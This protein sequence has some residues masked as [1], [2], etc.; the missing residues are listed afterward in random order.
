MNQ[1]IR[2]AWEVE[3]EAQAVR[4][5]AGHSTTEE[6]ERDR[7]R[8]AA[9]VAKVCRIGASSVGFEI[10]SGNGL[11]ARSL[12]ERCAR[13]ECNDISQSFLALARET[14]RHA[15]NVHFHLIEDNYLA[16][17]P[18]QAYDFGYSLNV[19]IHLNPFDMFIYLSDVARLLRPGGHFFF[20]ACTLGAQTQELFRE[21]ADAYR[22]E[23]ANVRGLLCFNDRRMIGEVVREAGLCVERRTGHAGWMKFLVRRP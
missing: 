23:P 21:A 13:L 22:Q 20:D 5:L 16:H 19:F 18:K 15:P 1:P 9:E 12:A 4:A 6:I 3:S 14:C 2:N 7:E 10:G 8:R 11:V 17:L